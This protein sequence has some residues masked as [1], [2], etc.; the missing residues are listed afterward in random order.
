[1]TNLEHRDATRRS[2]WQLI[3][4]CS[5]TRADRR[6]QYWFVA[7]TLAWGVSFVAAG[8]ALKNQPELSVRLIWLAVIVPNAF[9]VAAL[10][11]YLRFLRMADEL[12][13]KIQL[14][15]LAF[16]FG[17]GVIFCLAVQLLEQAGVLSLDAAD[18]AAV[19]MFAWVFGQLISMRR[20]G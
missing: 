6:N 5:G 7:W 19:M 3:K 2:W 12:L 15:G 13:Q 16:G 17:A 8:W 11:A 18:I 14:E 20:Y 9:A 1:M 4:S 10:L